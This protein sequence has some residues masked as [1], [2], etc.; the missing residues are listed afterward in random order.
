MVTMAAGQAPSV[1]LSAGGA[2]ALERVR[3][4]VGPAHPLGPGALLASFA[5]VVA[6]LF[7]PMLAA[8]SP[9]L[10]AARIPG[11]PAATAISRAAMGPNCHDPGM[12]ARPPR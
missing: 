11:F 3:R 12:A 2:G 6:L 5:I 8:A 7:A 4:L 1:A 10:A 9:A